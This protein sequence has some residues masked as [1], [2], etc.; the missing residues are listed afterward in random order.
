MEGSLFGE[1]KDRSDLGIGAAKAIEA[2]LLIDETDY[3]QA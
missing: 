2:H 1:E 3:L